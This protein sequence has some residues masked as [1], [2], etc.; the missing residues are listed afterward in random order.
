[1]NYVD[2]VIAVILAWA[3]WKGF[4]KGLVV[5]IFSILALFAGLY[6]A[7][8]FSD[9]VAI[10]LRDDLG[11]QREWIPIVSFAIIFIAVL[12]SVHLAARAIGKMLDLMALGFINKASGALFALMK[13]S[14]IMSFSLMLIRPFT[15]KMQLPPE[16]H[17]ENS[18]LY[19]PLRLLA[20]AVMPLIEESEVW[21]YLEQND[22][23][24][25]ADTDV[26][27]PDAL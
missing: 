22:W 16:E 19:E 18:M 10:W 11:M 5:E 25:S 7:I 24:P 12:I 13:V 17:L 3:G 26:N 6:L 20:P 21:N 27:F 14:L 4:R 1:M 8:R 9:V 23:L 2:I 15:A